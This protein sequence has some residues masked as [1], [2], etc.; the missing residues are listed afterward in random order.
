MDAPDLLRQRVALALSE[1][2]VVSDTAD[3]LFL[4]PGSVASYYD[5]LLE[6][7]FGS[8]EALLRAVSLH[9]AMG[10]Y[11]SHLNN[12]RSDPALGR[13]PDENYAREVMQLFSIGLFELEA[14]GSLRLD[15]ILMPLAIAAM[16]SP[17]SSPDSACRGPAPPSAARPGIAGCPW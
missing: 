2:F 9:P 1:I 6:H 7:A 15:A 14:D 8:Y 12:D 13:F 4:T 10:V 16:F 11:L 5:L 3:A 17:R